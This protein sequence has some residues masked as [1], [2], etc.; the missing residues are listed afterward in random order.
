MAVE[1]AVT[2]PRLMSRSAKEAASNGDR[3]DA[4]ESNNANATLLRHS[5]SSDRGDS[6]SLVN[7]L[8]R[9]RLR[10]L[11]RCVQDKFSEFLVKLR[12]R[13]RYRG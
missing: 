1:N 10:S 9:F 13:S 3:V 8:R 12:G 11:E 2:F 7:D 6:F 5:G 4:R